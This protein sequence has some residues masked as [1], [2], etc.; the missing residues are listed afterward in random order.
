MSNETNLTKEQIFEIFKKEIP[1]NKDERNMKN[2][3][4]VL[5]LVDA[6]KK[7]KNSLLCFGD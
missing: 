7:K 3:E 4:K 5:R 6:I 2:A 1:N